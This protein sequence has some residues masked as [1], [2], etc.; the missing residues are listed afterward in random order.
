MSF[1][2][3]LSASNSPGRPPFLI[4][5]TNTFCLTRIGGVNEKKSGKTIELKKNIISK[6]IQN[7]DKIQKKIIFFQF[8]NFFL[9]E[10]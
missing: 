7:E 2:P 8:Y 10:N 6:C 3:F 4:L 1:T 5:Y 9:P